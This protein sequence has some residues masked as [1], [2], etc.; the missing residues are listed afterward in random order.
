VLNH[1]GAAP[2]EHAYSLIESLASGW[3]AVVVRAGVGAAPFPVV[4]VRPL[5]PSGWMPRSD[6]VVYQ[7]VSRIT[8]TRDGLVLPP[9]RSAQ[10]RHILAGHVDPRWRWVKAFA[11]V[12]ETAWE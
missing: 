1:G 10:V 8:G 7:R 5:F 9:L 3:P 4:P 2:S 12:W 11:P 6:R